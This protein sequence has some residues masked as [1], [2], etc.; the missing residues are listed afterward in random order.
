MLLVIPAKTGIQNYLMAGDSRRTIAPMPG[1]K[2]QIIIHLVRVES[3][4]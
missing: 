2:L 4:F 1:Q 3:L